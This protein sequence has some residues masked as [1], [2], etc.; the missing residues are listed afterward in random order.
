MEI[1]PAF[2]D[3]VSSEHQYQMSTAEQRKQER[4]Q[5]WMKICSDALHNSRRHGLPVP[6]DVL[7]SGHLAGPDALRRPSLIQEKCAFNDM[8]PLAKSLSGL[9]PPALSLASSTGVVHG[10]NPGGDILSKDMRTSTPSSEMQLFEDREVSPNSTTG[11][12]HTSEFEDAEQSILH[13]LAD[14][15][16]P[17]YLE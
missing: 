7:S 17:A 2:F 10:L 11:T 9:A 8:I 16:V 6:D 4:E 15:I 13:D 12:S 1:N 5:A 3:L 14:H